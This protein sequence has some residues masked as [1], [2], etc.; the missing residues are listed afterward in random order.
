MA[1]KVASFHRKDKAHLTWN[2]EAVSMEVFDESNRFRNPVKSMGFRV[3]G[4]EVV[5]VSINK[6][7]EIQS[8]IGHHIS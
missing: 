1:S 5:E 3:V 2:I 6:I 4:Y 7:P 8:W